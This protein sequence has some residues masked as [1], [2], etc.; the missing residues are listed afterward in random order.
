WEDSEGDTLIVLANEQQSDD[1]IGLNSYW[2]AV[3]AVRAWRGGHF[4]AVVVSGGSP[5]GVHKSM[6]AVIGD[7]LAA[8]GIPREKIFLEEKSLSTRENAQY[9]KEMIGNWPGRN[10][11]LTSDYHTFRALR[12]FRA[13]GL[14]VAPRPFPDVIKQANSIVNRGPCFWG[15][16][17]ETAKIAYYRARGWI[18]L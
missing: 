5:P 2:R 12:V 18:T 11:L 10:V 14:E 15:L 13:A 7:F 1:I 8:N 16:L 9:T 4:R 17:V 3:Y 6:A